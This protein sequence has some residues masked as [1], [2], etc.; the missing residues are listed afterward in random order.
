MIYDEQFITY[1][2]EIRRENIEHV[3]IVGCSINMY[4]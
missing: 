1:V 4:V 3:R 2:M